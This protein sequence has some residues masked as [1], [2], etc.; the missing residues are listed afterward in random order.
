MLTLL[1]YSKAILKSLLSGVPVSL[2]G[3]FNSRSLLMGLMGRWAENIDLPVMAIAEAFGVTPQAVY[4]NINR[5]KQLEAK[6]DAQPDLPDDCIVLTPRDIDKIVLASALDANA[7]LEGIQRVLAAIDCNN[8]PRSI[9]HISEFLSRAGAFA[10]E[11]L[12]TIPLDGICHGANDEVFDG[13]DKPVLTGVD[14]DSTYIYLMQSM[15]DR[16]GETWKQAMETLKNL[17]LNLKVAISDAGSGLLKGVKAAFPDADTQL[18]LFH[19]LRDIGRPVYRFKEH[20]FKE[21]AECY[22]LENAVAK[23][24]RPWSKR[25][26]KRKKKLAD[27]KAKIPGMI[28][29]FD[30]LDILYSWLREMV[31][32]N[33]YSYEEVMEL[34]NWLLDEM[35]AV[36]TRHSWAYKLSNEILRFRERMP[37]TMRFIN[38]LFRDFNL[39]AE[40]MGLPEEVFRLLYRRFGAPKESEAYAELTRQASALIPSGELAN[41]EKVHDEIVNG[42]KR[43]SSMVE[44]VNGRLRAYMNIKK[45]VSS[46]FYSLVQLHLNAK[47]YRRSR[48]ESRKGRSPLELLTGKPWPE[49]IDLLEESGF[50]DKDTAKQ[51]A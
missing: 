17:G 3:G 24:K 38:R 8:H 12:K 33:G 13:S 40:A 46:N 27:Y 22:E 41:V 37:V 5:L 32:F 50:W 7:S 36:S 20:V 49:F 4:G 11:I 25:A 6:I 18:D 16:K 21:L 30:T 48:V 1:Y 14:P 51:V 23:E 31:S 2:P 42:I 39:T 43:A 44:N 34:M 28:E 35:F 47:K 45:H 26:E 19:I 9:G 29:D 15:D 10:A